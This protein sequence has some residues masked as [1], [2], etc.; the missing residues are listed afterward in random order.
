MN[1]NEVDQINEYQ[2]FTMALM[3]SDKNRNL[4]SILIT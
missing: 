3:F 1:A 4:S 2:I